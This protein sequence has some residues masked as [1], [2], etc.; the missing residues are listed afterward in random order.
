M[1]EI[2]A[3]LGRTP[4]QVLLRWCLQH[5]V[6]TIPKSRTHERI[7]ENADVLDWE[8]GEE[9]MARLDALRGG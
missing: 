5:G 6:P 4:A 3:R 1:G 7:A 8:L 9:D 2:A